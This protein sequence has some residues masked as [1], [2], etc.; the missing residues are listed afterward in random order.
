VCDYYIN[1][2]EPQQPLE[3]DLMRRAFFKGLITWHILETAMEE[4]RWEPNP[5]TERLVPQA[6]Q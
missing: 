6:L 5:Q 3:T 4:W 1:N 2:K